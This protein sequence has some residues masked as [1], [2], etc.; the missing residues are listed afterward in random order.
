MNL[1]DVFTGAAVIVP[2]AICLLVAVFMIAAGWK[3]FV[4]AGQP[5]WAVIIPI[6][7]IVVILKIVGRPL[8]WIVLMVIPLVNLAIAIIVNIDFAKSFGKSAGFGVGLALLGFI[9]FPILGFGDARYI[10]PAALA[11]ART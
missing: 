6:Y 3:V 9:F 1:G 8:W 5:G 11:P 4:K 2:I 10:G 7:N